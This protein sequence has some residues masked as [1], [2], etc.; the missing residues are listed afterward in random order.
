MA[1]ARTRQKRCAHVRNQSPFLTTTMLILSITA[2][3]TASP[4]DP[5]EI[6]FSKDETLDIDTSSWWWQARKGDGTLGFAPSS[7][8][9][10]IG[11]AG[12]KAKALYAYT[13]S[14]DEPNDISFSAGETLDIIEK[15]GDWWQARKEDGTLGTAPSNYLRITNQPQP[16]GYKAKALYAYTASPDD[17]SDISFS[18]GETLDIIEKDG[19]WWQARKEDGTLGIAPSN[20]LRITD[21]PQPA[22]YKAKALYAYTASPDE[23]SDISF[24]EG[25]T[26]DIIEKDGD[27]W[28]ARKEN[29][30]FG[31]VPSNFLRIIKRPQLAGYK[32]LYAR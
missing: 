29:G 30:T 25:E 10:I 4:N 20:Y 9:R 27:W 11:R 26:L 1:R 18:A 13:A 24:S 5:N 16:A 8:L 3:D 6:S 15:D 19:D 14:P 23:P 31:I 28:Q 2:A 22:G 12:Y 32:A 17:P 7:Y 21:Q